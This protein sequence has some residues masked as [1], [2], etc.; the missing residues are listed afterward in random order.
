MANC[1]N[2]NSKLPFFK[3]GFLSKR[4]NFIECHTCNTKMLGDT[5]LLSKIG[6]I[7]GGFASAFIATGLLFFRN[8]IFILSS[9][10]FFGIT[11]V[12]LGMIIQNQKLKLNSIS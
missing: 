7:V 8:N 6:G 11:I 10:I 9:F 12:F 4:K 2:C 1:I 5:K 3:V